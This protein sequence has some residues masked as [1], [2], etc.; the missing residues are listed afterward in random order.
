MKSHTFR[1]V[2][3][4]LFLCLSPRTGAQQTRLYRGKVFIG[5]DGDT[6]PLPKDPRYESTFGIR[7]T[8]V[9]AGSSGEHAGLRIG[10]TIVSIDGKA[11]TSEKIRLS[12]S[13]GKAGDKATPGEIVPVQVLRQDEQAPDAARR[14]ETV[15]VTLQPYPRTAPEQPRT[16]AND[17]L[18]P[19]LKQASPAYEGLCWE[20]I[21]AAGYETDCRDLLA[22]IG[23]CEQYPDPDRL[24]LMRYV[25]RDPFR[26]EAVSREIIDAVE[27]EPTRG[28]GDLAFFLD[29][30]RHVLIT[31]D[32]RVDQSVGGEAVTGELA[33]TNYAGKDLK[34]HLDYVEE[35]LKAAAAVHKT[36]FARISADEMEFIL[37][38]R[39]GLIESFIEHKMLSYDRKYER[40][41]A[42]VQLLDMACKVDVG[43]LIDQARLVALLVQ[44]GFVASLKKAAEAGDLDLDAR[45]VA[46][47]KTP[48]GAV[49]VAGRGRTRYQGADYAVI[50]ELGG[51]DVYAN[52]QATSIWGSIPS[53]VVVDYAGD[54]AYETYDAFRQG[55]GDAGVGILVDLQGDD[56]YV[57]TSFTQGTAFMGIGMLV[58]ESGDDTYRGI[59]L[60]QGV[61]HWGVGVLADRGGNDRYE[62]HMASQGVGMPGGF[63]LLCDSGNGTDSYYC[64]GNQGTGYGTP[65][66]YEGWGQGVGFGFRPYASGGVGVLIDRGG[67]DRMEAGNFSQGGGYYYGFGIL[68]AGG[69]DA[70]RYIGSRYAQGFGCHQAAGVMIEAGGNDHYSTRN[71]VAQGLAWD[72][73]VALFLEA[74]GDDL[75]EGGGFSQGASAMNGWTL[76]LDMAGRDT[77]RYTDQARAGG[78]SY[79]GGTSLS[80]FV[81]AGGD[82]D[83]YPQKPNNRIVTGGEKSLFVD[84][85]GTLKLTAEIPLQ[86]LKEL[87]VPA[88]K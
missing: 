9:A 57:G 70:D 37:K 62:S 45:V 83:S 6:M 59:Q 29:Q 52:N 68:Y 56:T 58:D 32:R 27:A 17:E 38:H 41:K 11:W 80:F 69:N 2:A 39:D 33:G 8:R 84:L 35:V 22:R 16:P 19:E 79:H 51:N 65:G 3:S 47:R 13:F 21:K 30:A 28:V 53:A 67:A 26:L 1:L 60:H 49:L 72:E 24:A 15:E 78:N 74:A 61:G 48:F 14:F 88:A 23:R 55:C 85:P 87:M 75:Y 12:R 54:D 36:A 86:K 7:L 20:L 73:A 76:F 82:E 4:F 81:D 5:I 18:R 31:F 50:Y 34:G 71:A 42:S 46:Q 40:Q 63:G 10:D 77:Y 64:K 44:P 66:V 25:H 43:A